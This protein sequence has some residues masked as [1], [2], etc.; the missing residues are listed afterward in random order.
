VNSFSITSFGYGLYLSKSALISCSSC[1]N[2]LDS[3]I[4]CAAVFRDLPSVSDF[5][6]VAT[7]RAVDIIVIPPCSCYSHLAACIWGSN[8]PTAS[9]KQIGQIPYGVEMLVDFEGEELLVAESKS[10]AVTLQKQF[11]KRSERHSKTRW[12]KARDRGFPIE[13][14][15]E[16]FTVEG[17][18]Q[19]LENGADGIGV[20]KVDKLFPKL[21][22]I[23]SKAI[24]ISELVN[25]NQK[26]SP[27]RIRFFDIDLQ[28]STKH[29]DYIPNG[30]L[31][32]RGVRILEIQEEW[33]NYFEN[34][35]DAF[36][37][38]DIE[39]VLPMVTGAEEIARFR[40]NIDNKWEKVGATI[41]TPSAALRIEEIVKVSDFIE[42]GLNDLTQYTMAWDRN[43]PN[44]ERLPTCRI[45]DPVAG[46]ISNV[47]SVCTDAKVPYTLGLDLRPSK[48]LA[49]QI[50]SLGVES[51]SCVPPLV[52]YW[53]AF[54]KKFII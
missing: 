31:G 19:A 16:P 23:E 21:E 30:S 10:D 49:E 46:L 20:V 54:T 47:A 3:D 5:T 45:A 13:V 7:H 36:G 44:N 52:E 42:I 22:Y 15:A 40:E 33:I 14:L 32:Y 38:D 50:H 48:K 8:V 34:C 26:L 53:K 41:E 24:K 17:F 11:D 43:I 39:I 25:S 37:I 4:L 28:H 12:S 1:T 9:V 6:E 29:T 27:L 2:M 51:I 18:S 35:I